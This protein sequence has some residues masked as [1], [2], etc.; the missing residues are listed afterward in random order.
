VRRMTGQTSQCDPGNGLEQYKSLSFQLN[1]CLEGETSPLPVAVKNLTTVGVI[2]EILHVGNGFKTESLKG[3]EGLLTIVSQDDCVMNEVPGKI[4]WTHK[5]DGEA[6]V[7]LGL[8]LLEPLPLSVRQRLET[9]MAIGAKDMKVLW[10][11]WDEIKE[12]AAPVESP[13]PVMSI[14]L[15]PDHTA[16]PDGQPDVVKGDNWWYWVGFGAILSGLGMQYPQS[17]YLGFAGLI[18]MF[19]GSLVV[20]WKSIASMRQVSSSGSIDESRSQI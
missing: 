4:L 9:T 6:G 2:L 12:A 18:T 3:R 17:D 13:E 5:R 11:Y 15:V 8:E 7:T 14:P 10:D 1:N 16:G 20:A 19:L